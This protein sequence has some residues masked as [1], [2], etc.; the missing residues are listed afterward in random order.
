MPFHDKFQCKM[1][2]LSS[3]SG[4]RHSFY[5]N[6]NDDIVDKREHHHHHHRHSSGSSTHRHSSANARFQTSSEAASSAEVFL[7]RL[8]GIMVRGV[9]FGVLCVLAY[10]LWTKNKELARDIENYKGTNAVLVEQN[11]KLEDEKKALLL[12]IQNLERDKEDLAEVNRTLINA[13]KQQ[14]DAAAPG[15]KSEVAPAPAM[16]TPLPAIIPE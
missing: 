11:G 10:A 8:P 3:S 6:D 16:F 14:A 2:S 5:D 15:F 9:L 7:K 13:M 12:E 4:S 1:S